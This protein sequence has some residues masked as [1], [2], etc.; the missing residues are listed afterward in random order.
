MVWEAMRWQRFMS[1]ED[2]S[3]Y[4]LNDH[5]HSRYARKIMEDE[6]DLANV[7]ELRK[8]KS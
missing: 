6:P 3:I 5:Y 2:P 4:K 8:L 7:F 1:T